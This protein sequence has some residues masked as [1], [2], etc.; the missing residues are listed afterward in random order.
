MFINFLDSF[1]ENFVT[2]FF[3]FKTK[4]KAQG[5]QEGVT[6]LFEK[7]KIS[8]FISSQDYIQILETANEVSLGYMSFVLF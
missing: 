6:M 1:N 3:F 2:S 4:R 7:K 5:Y 8:E